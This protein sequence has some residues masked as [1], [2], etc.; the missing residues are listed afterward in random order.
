[1]IPT[2][3]HGA[4]LSPGLHMDD[5]PDN[6]HKL[7]NGGLYG[8]DW[9]ENEPAVIYSV[10]RDQII[11]IGE[12]KVDSSKVLAETLF[13]LCDIKGLQ[14]SFGDGASSWFRD[15]LHETGWDLICEQ[16][17]RAMYDVACSLRPAD[18]PF[19]A[20]SPITNI[21][22]LG[23]WSISTSQGYED[24]APEIDEVTFAGEGKV[25]LANETT[26]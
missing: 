2:Q 21:S 23:L 5:P 11:K 8:I 19:H 17:M 26:Y 15:F 9:L 3:I 1:M 6:C 7:I 18:Q 24:I 22:F 14:E 12:E 10:D 20:A 13:C 25:V 16:D 4:I